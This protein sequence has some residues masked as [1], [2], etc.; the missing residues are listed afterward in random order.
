[1]NKRE[2]YVYHAN[3]NHGTIEIFNI[4]DHDFFCKGC[5]EAYEKFGKI[6]VKFAEEVKHELMYFYWSKVEWEVEIKD[7]FYDKSRKIDV[8][9]QIMLNWRVFIDY[10][11]DWYKGRDTR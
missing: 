5:D 4:F 6:K 2:W 8:Y 9:E 10:L 7:L 1:M 11:W 3:L